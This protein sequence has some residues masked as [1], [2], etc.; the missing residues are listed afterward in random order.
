LSVYKWLMSKLDP[1]TEYA[2]VIPLIDKSFSYFKP[3]KNNQ[4]EFVEV[5]TYSPDE[6]EKMLIEKTDEL[7]QFIDLDVE[8]DQCSN[9]FLYGRK[10]Q[11][12]KKMKCLHYCDFAKHC[13]YF[14][15]HSALKNI[16]DL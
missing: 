10:G 13:K 3:I 6:I 1:G 9:L 4:L 11:P 2:T 5:E 14:N 8:P 7:Q 16:L 12:V 15:D